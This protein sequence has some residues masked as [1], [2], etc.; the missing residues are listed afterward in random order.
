M[1]KVNALSVHNKD[2]S[3]R[4]YTLCVLKVQPGSNPQDDEEHGHTWGEA[5]GEHT[6]RPCSIQSIPYFYYHWDTF[7]WVVITLSHTLIQFVWWL[8]LRR[9]SFRLGLDEMSYGYA[10]C[11]PYRPFISFRTQR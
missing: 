1:C 10:C 11:C 2:K 8:Q 5:E 4:L 7:T 6:E 3:G 9:E